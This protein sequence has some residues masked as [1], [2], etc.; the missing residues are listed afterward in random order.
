MCDLEKAKGPA[1][2]GRP[3]VLCGGGLTVKNGC[4]QEDF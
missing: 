4:G 3:V 1:G 2:G